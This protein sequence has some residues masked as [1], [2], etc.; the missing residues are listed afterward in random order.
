[1]H[2]APSLR[3][4]RATGLLALAC[5]TA[6][7]GCRDAPPPQ[8]VE[9]GD[10]NRGRQLIEQF[11]CGACHTIPDV[12]AARGKTGPTLDHFGRRSYIAGHIPNRPANLVNWIVDPPSQVP[13]TLMPDMGVSPHDARDMAA[14]LLSLE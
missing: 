12:S 11:Q 1:M 7:S 2:I 14:Y 5:C 4:V 10:R 9:G 8:A 3:T 13:G 6:L